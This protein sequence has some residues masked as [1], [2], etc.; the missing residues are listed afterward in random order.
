MQQ[1]YQP[2][3]SDIDEPQDQSQDKQLIDPNTLRAGFIVGLDDDGKFFYST[4]GHGQTSIYELLG[5]NE[6]ATDLLK[7]ARDRG[8]SS[9]VMDMQQLNYRLHE[10]AQNLGL[11]IERLSQI[12]ALANLKT[13]G[14]ISA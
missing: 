8:T 10:A 9:L 1:G 14:E 11:S 2:T 13:D 6:S 5:L 12:V 3:E 4:C 7:Y